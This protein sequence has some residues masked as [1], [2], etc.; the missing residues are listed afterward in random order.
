MA[1]T[2]ACL[3]SACSLIIAFAL[4][5]SLVEPN[6]LVVDV[7]KLVSELMFPP[8]PSQQP[9]QADWFHMEE[10]PPVATVVLEILEAVALRSADFNGN[11]QNVFPVAFECH[12]ISP[13]CSCTISSSFNQTRFH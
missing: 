8:P 5:Q 11:S 10:K 2:L 3:H 1:G 6:M 12:I 7:E 9:K 4:E 13:T